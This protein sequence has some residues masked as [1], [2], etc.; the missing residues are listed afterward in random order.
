MAK[1]YNLLMI[2][3]LSLVAFSIYSPAYS[4]VTSFLFF[5]L[6]KLIYSC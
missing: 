4:A 5:L 1:Q 6:E 3:D 2:H